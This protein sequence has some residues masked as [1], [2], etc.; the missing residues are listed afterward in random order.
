MDQS[1]SLR[2]LYKVQGRE[3]VRINA[4]DA[5]ARGIANGDLIDVFNDRGRI[6]CQSFVTQ[7]IMPG[8]I[9]VPQGAWLKLDD[10][11][12]DHGGVANMLT[13]WHPTPYAK[14]NAQ[15]TALVQAEKAAG[16]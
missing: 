14:G 6:R 11:G 3:P 9:S 4:E 1:Q 8:V 5:A 16:A 7:R 13:S 15:M 10:D 2:D 12:V